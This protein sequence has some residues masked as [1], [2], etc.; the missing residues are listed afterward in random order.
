MA[1]SRVAAYSWVLPEGAG[2]KGAQSSG[3]F[4]GSQEQLSTRPYPQKMWITLWVAVF[5]T[6]KTTGKTAKVL[7]WSNNYR[8]IKVCFFSQLHRLYGET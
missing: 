1:V 5:P 3:P 7:L 6:V 2:K 4:L 8:A